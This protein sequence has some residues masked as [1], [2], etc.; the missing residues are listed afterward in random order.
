[1]A[2]ST[3]DSLGATHFILTDWILMLLLVVGTQLRVTSQQQYSGNYC[4]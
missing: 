2:T 1:M 4:E 3:R